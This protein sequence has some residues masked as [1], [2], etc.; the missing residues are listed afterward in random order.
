MN[1]FIGTDWEYGTND[2][3]SVFVKAS[4]AVFDIDLP[5]VIIPDKSDASANAVL[6]KL[7]AGS[8][9]WQRIKELEPGCAVL[10]RDDL[11]NAVHIGLHIE[12][13][14]ILHCAGSVEKPG[15]TVYCKLRRLFGVYQ[16]TE[17]YRYA[18]DNSR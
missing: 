14:N 1:Q 6:F 17:F 18:P 13:G 11:D 12:G 10:F 5:D 16:N 15:R 8:S 3:W 4:K 9:N 2:C 7:Y